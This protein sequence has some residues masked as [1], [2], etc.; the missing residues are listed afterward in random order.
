[1]YDSRL[2][3]G[4]RNGAESLPRLDGLVD[5]SAE[6]GKVGDKIRCCVSRVGD[7]IGCCVGVDGDMIGC[8]VGEAIPIGDLIILPA[9]ELLP[10]A[11]DR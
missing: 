1:M 2:R 10:A 4:V 5:A 9:G 8:C 11:R 6:A 7:M 3:F